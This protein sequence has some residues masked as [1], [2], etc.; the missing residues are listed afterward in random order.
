M[1]DQIELPIF[2]SEIFGAIIE[3]VSDGKTFKALMGSC[4]YI[5]KKHKHKYLRYC[6][7]LW[8]LVLRYPKK[9]WNWKKI[10]SNINTTLELIEKYSDT[11]NYPNIHLNWK[12][13]S[14][15]PNLTPE[16]I[17]KYPIRP[18][19]WRRISKNAMFAP[20]M[21]KY[22]SNGGLHWYGISQNPNLTPEFIL[23][24]FHKLYSTHIFQHP[25]VTME[26][27]MKMFDGEDLG[28][29]LPYRVSGNPNIT[30]EFVNKYPGGDWDWNR[31][32]RNRGISMED[33]ENNPDKPWNY[34]YVSKNPNLTIGF[35]RKYID[36]GWDFSEIAKNPNISPEVLIQLHRDCRNQF[37]LKLWRFSRNPNLTIDFIESYFFQCG[38]FGEPL[39]WNE[40]SRNT[41]GKKLK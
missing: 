8:T 25:N 22:Y 11:K 10:S 16:F 28:V 1:N 29:V 17:E 7:Q 14:K 23:E 13:V 34:E 6:N 30:I 39:V 24:H 20:D 2:P 32:S 35:V 37:Q 36:K 5:N 40:I 31:L 41:F 21:E 33:I 15:N 3:F 12:W 27:L 38:Y 4:S 19:T 26:F 9:P 18:W